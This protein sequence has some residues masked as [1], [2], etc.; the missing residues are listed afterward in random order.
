LQLGLLA[1]ERRIGVAGD[2]VE[3]SGVAVSGMDRGCNDR[4]T[5]RIALN[6]SQAERTAAGRFMRQTAGG[7]AQHIA[8]ACQDIFAAASALPAG[9]Q[10]QAPENYY[11]DL[12]ARFDLDDAVLSRMHAAGIFYD[13]IGNGEFFQVYTRSINGLFF[14]LVERRGDYD[15]YGEADA[16]VRLAAQAALDRS[17]AAIL[18]ELRR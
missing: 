13:S 8:F 17:L 14:E 5:L 7:G 3:V 16:P 15:R 18:T 4:R 12:A 6:V 2:R 10:L 1:P 9:L 11:E